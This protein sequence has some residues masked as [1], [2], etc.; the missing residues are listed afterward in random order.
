MGTDAARKDGGLRPLSDICGLE[1]DGPGS[2]AEDVGVAASGLSQ[3]MRDHQAAGQS[4]FNLTA[5]APVMDAATVKVPGRHAPGEKGIRKG[6]SPGRSCP[7]NCE[8]R[9]GLHPCH[10]AL[11]REDRRPAP[12]REPGDLP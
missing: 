12:T 4:Q 10:W 2:G 6:H 3:R 9:A 8:R 1:T 5:R 11:A 7:R